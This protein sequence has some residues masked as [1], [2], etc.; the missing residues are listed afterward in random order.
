[1]KKEIPIL[2]LFEFNMK[3]FGEYEVLVLAKDL[4]S[5][6]ELACKEFESYYGLTG[7]NRETLKFIK[8]HQKPL[9]IINYSE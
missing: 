6:R 9:C 1:M 8:C 4:K 5:A 3:D 7:L 2:K